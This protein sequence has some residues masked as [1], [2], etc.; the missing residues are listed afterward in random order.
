MAAR[1]QVAARQQRRNLMNC[2][3]RNARYVNEQTAGCSGETL[4][5]QI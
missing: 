3:G 4:L 2:C 5:W 1:V